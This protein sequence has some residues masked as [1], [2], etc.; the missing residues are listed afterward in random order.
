MV[1]SSLHIT[2]DSEASLKPLTEDQVEAQ[3]SYLTEIRSFE[4][5]FLKLHDMT[6]ID[7]P[8]FIGVNLIKIR[9]RLLPI[10]LFGFLSST[11]MIYDA[12]TDAF[13]DIIH[14]TR[15]HF[16]HESVINMPSK[17]IYSLNTGLTYP[18][19]VTASNCRVR[20]IRRE[21]IDI[22]MK[23]PWREGIQ[24]SF[25]SGL[26]GRFTMQVE[27]EGL[28]PDEV[29]PEERRA[30][31]FDLKFKQVGLKRTLQMKATKGL[32]EQREYVKETW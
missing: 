12:Y 9:S 10:M 20:H 4:R 24:V 19:Y 28:G 3:L 11:E 14:Y 17:G 5:C 30:L 21:A 31:M 16:A 23:N 6:P 22:L 29:I 27:E 32:K 13:Q 25:T 18:L 7:S 2:F 15:I 8:D 26:I 1:R